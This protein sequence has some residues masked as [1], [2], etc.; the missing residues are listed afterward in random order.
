MPTTT[1]PAAL[2]ASD[3]PEGCSYPA[4]GMPSCHR[5]A[6]GSDKALLL[7]GHGLLVSRP[8]R[9]QISFL[10]AGATKVTVTCYSTCFLNNIQTLRQP[11]GPKS[12]GRQ[13]VT[14]PASWEGKTHLPPQ[15]HPPERR[16]FALFCFAFCFL[17]RGS[18]CLVLAA[19]ELTT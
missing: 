9:E 14:L 13:S 12:P 1:G 8:P 3:S 11:L 15:C 19:L 2:A 4:P 16:C 5:G 6:F 7:P 17:R 10:A 18:L